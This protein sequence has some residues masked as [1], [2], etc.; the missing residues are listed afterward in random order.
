MGRSAMNEALVEVKAL[1]KI[2]PAVDGQVTKVL[3]GINFVIEPGSRIALIGP[4]GSG[5]STL[6]HI[7]GGFIE[8]TEGEVSWPGLGAQQDLLPEKVQA[9]FQAS[10]LFP[11]LTVR[12]NI[13]LPLLLAGR[14]AASGFAPEGLLARFGL[15][16]LALKLPEDL[17]GEPNRKHRE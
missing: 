16:D 14:S 11:A 3:S 17:S 7:I 12:D 15:S 1:G 6:L 2:Y 10:S 4:S 9:V 13:A 5:K 8:P